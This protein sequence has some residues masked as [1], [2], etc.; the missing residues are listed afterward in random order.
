MS[1]VSVSLIAG[2]PVFLWIVFNGDPGR[3][4]IVAGERR[5]LAAQKA[6]LHE[7]PIVV[8]DLDDSETLEVAI[9]ENIQR[10]NLNSI[11]ESEAYAVLQGKFNLSQS[12]IAVSVGKSRTTITNALRLL[13]LPIE[14]KKSISLRIYFEKDFFLREYFD[15]VIIFCTRS[16]TSKSN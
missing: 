10:E 1:K 2:L 12:K 16:F 5:W 7:V 3:Y 4:E 15:Y 11:E 8:L 9:V 13:Q 6:G 14:V